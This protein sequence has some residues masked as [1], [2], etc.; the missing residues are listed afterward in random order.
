MGAPCPI[1]AGSKYNGT[2]HRHAD[3]MIRLFTDALDG[4]VVEGLAITVVNFV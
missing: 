2:V 1:Y 4:N 3:Y